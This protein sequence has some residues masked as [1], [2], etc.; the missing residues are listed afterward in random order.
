MLSAF[1]ALLQEGRL[2]LRVYVILDAAKKPLVEEWLR[3]GLIAA[4]NRL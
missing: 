4:T 1:R 2:P 3:R